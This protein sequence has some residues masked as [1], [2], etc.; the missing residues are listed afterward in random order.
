MQTLS[1]VGSG[2]FKTR[3]GG[4]VGTAGENDTGIAAAGGSGRENHG[5][6]FS[7]KAKTEPLRGAASQKRAQRQTPAPSSPRSTRRK[8]LTWV[9]YAFLES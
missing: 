9:L 3:Q 5:G 6:M 8:K 2:D 7:F 4:L 1:A